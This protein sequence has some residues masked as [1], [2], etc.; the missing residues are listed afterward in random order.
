M[1]AMI[2]EKKRETRKKKLTTRAAMG[3]WGG[4]SQASK[5]GCGRYWMHGCCHCQ[6]AGCIGWLG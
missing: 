2:G 1:E 4:A 5:E 3:R 6:L